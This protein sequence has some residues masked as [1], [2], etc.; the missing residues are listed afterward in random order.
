MPAGTQRIGPNRRLKLRKVNKE[1]IMATLTK[2]PP[3]GKEKTN[4]YRTRDTSNDQS[5]RQHQPSDTGTKMVNRFMC[6]E[7]D[8]PVGAGG[9]AQVYAQVREIKLWLSHQDIVRW[10][11]LTGPG[12]QGEI[13][14]EE[15][16][17]TIAFLTDFPQTGTSTTSW[18][19]LVCSLLKRKFKLTWCIGN[20]R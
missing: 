19:M 4:T 18:E 15:L 16:A 8:M 17:R 7:A 9:W 11:G 20:V 3:T 2:V 6:G 13:E 14:R 12:T 5:P 10:M 1:L